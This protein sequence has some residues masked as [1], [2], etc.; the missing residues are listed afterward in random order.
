MSAIFDHSQMENHIMD[1]DGIED[2]RGYW[3]SETSLQ[4][5]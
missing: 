4:D 1:W 2:K 5:S 3:N